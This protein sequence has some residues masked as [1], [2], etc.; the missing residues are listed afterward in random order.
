VAARRAINPGVENA[1]SPSPAWRTVEIRGPGARGESQMV[2]R[3]CAL[4]CM[5]GLLL[6]GRNGPTASAQSDLAPYQ[7]RFTD[8]APAEQ[9]IA[10]EMR[11]GLT[12]AET[13]RAQTHAWPTVEAL[14]SDGIPPFAPDPL[15]PNL[16]WT[17]TRDGATFNYLGQS[18]KGGPSYLI[19]IQE[20]LPGMG[21][22]P[23]TP[24]D[25]IHHKLSDGTILHVYS[26]VRDGP[27]P[28]NAVTGKPWLDG[29][30]QLVLDSPKEK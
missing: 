24:P 14:A 19:V 2:L 11:E 3:A 17:L 23:Q 25:E 18:N 7:L 30:K 29:W 28:S 6:I 13:T 9:R 10:R 8:L 22:P 27:P 26:C 21:D 5:A 16:R 4:V 20:P 12:E 15:A 1:P